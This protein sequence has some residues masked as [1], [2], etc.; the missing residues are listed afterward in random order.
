MKTRAMI[1][2]GSMLALSGSDI[3]F[4]SA[5]VEAQPRRA[6]SLCAANETPLFQC[7]VGRKMAAVC[8]GR[9][10]GRTYA[11]YRFGRPGALELTYPNSR[12]GSGTLRRA[13]IPFSGGGEA[14]F[15]FTS[16]NHQ[17]VVFSRTV[18]TSFGAGGNNPEFSAGVT[19]RRN[20][21]VLRTL[22][23]SDGDSAN[24]DLG[25]AERFIPEGEPVQAD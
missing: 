3:P 6:A 25:A 17:Y 8:G 20:G 16:G 9:S 18:R 12:N 5:P 21:R 22:G 24:V 11:Q 2:A 14:Q 1:L 15:H 13:S 7:R 19:V 4:T 23:C 10:G